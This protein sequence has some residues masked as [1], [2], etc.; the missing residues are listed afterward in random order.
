MLSISGYTIVECINEGSKNIIYRAIRNDNNTPII[1]KRPVSE[2]PDLSVISM[3]KHEYE[4]N[5]IIN[6]N[7]IVKIY[8]MELVNNI[9]ILFEEDFGGTSLQKI[10]KNRNLKIVEFLN[11]ANKITEALNNIHECNIVHNDIN[12]S[13]IIVN[14]ETNTVK[15][16][17]F[18]LAAMFSK[19]SQCVLD[20][21]FGGTLSYISPEQ[22]G[23]MKCS[24]DY[25]SDLYSLGV[26]F[27]EML[28]GI[29][30]FQAS[31]EIGLIHSHLA[32]IPEAPNKLNALIPR[33]LSDI[34]M[35]LMEK[36][37]ENRYQ[38]APGLKHDLEKCVSSL[39]ANGDIDYF[40]LAQD[41]ISERFKITDELY[42]RDN[43]I[44]V[45]LSAFNRIS[46]GR[47]EIVVVKGHSG[48]GK[49]ALINE[50]NSLDF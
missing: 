33:I 13:N 16:T 7:K 21:S 42:G 50:I 5:N 4:I 45:L 32:I 38:S 46:K 31:D 9:P 37:T 10:L 36:N 27:Y 12:P 11:I 43:E 34:I 28:T 25:R 17:G 18:G 8:G 19:Q 14:L 49:S 20:N 24:I 26:S 29:L 2:Y 39:Q 40:I 6:S 30:P 47:K 3:L 23:R 22:T 48:V 44:E 1:I 35:K 15:I 41:D